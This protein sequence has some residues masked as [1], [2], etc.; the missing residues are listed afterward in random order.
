MPTYTFINVETEEETT[1]VMSLSERDEFLKDGKYK[2]KLITPR[3]VSQSGSTLSKTDDGWKDTLRRVKA[4]SAK[5][6]TINV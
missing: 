4:G 5:S 1:S 2:Q 3:I 6:N